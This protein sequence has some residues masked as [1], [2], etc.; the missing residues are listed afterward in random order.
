MVVEEAGVGDV[1]KNFVVSSS[2]RKLGERQRLQESFMMQLA[3]D[4]IRHFVKM[5][6]VLADTTHIVKGDGIEFRERMYSKRIRL[7]DHIL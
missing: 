6:F 5:I 2:I 7:V 3:A 1:G 4:L